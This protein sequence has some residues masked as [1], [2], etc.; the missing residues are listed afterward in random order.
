MWDVKKYHAA[1]KEAKKNG[2]F[3]GRE[4]KTQEE[5]YK[6]LGDKVGVTRDTAK[7]WARAGNKGPGENDLIAK[8]EQ[9]FKLR[10]G[11][12]G[13]RDEKKMKEC[14]KK[15]NVTDFN[16]Y[17]IFRCFQTMKEFLHDDKLELEE[18]FADMYQQIETYGIGIP[19]EI[20][21]KILECIDEFLAP[22]VYDRERTFAQC[23]TDEIGSWQSDGSWRTKDKEG[24]WKFC[25][26]F[27]MKLVEIE[28]KIDAFAMKTLYVQFIV[29][30][31]VSFLYRIKAVQ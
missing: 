16:K 14:K 11:E 6:L 9:A 27:R 4:A 2:E 13:R 24:T 29:G 20:F 10:P 17:L 22:I 1:I 5:I 28:E 8:V 30:I 12:L 26:N 15:T 25:I 21:K 18:C 7:S 23:Y 19:E 3:L 31:L